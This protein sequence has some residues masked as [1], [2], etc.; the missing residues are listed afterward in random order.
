[1]SQERRKFAR[2]NYTTSIKWKNLATSAEGT[3]LIVDISKD[4][5]AGGIRM[6]L[7]TMLEVGEEIFVKF[8]FPPNKI[9][10]LKG[11]VRWS[12]KVELSSEKGKNTIY[13]AGIEFLDMND[14][15]IDSID[16]IVTFFTSPEKEIDN[17]EDG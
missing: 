13:Y 2:M 3:S 8:R 6:I 4:I 16:Q 15:D 14:E 17:A 9:F 7:N 11:Q 12:K 10:N 1:M 5:S